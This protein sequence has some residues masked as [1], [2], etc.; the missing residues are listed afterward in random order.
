MP[1]SPEGG[2]PIKIVVSSR[3]ESLD[4]QDAWEDEEEDEMAWEDPPTDPPP[5]LHMPVASTLEV[6]EVVTLDERIFDLAGDLWGEEPD[7]MF[8]MTLDVVLEVVPCE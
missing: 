2:P 7:A 6:A 4:E 1:Q 8:R 3:S 5:S